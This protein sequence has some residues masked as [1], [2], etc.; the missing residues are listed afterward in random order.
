MITDPF[1]NSRSSAATLELPSGSILIRFAGAGSP[2]PI[3]SKPK[4]PAQAR[5]V[6]GDDHVVEV[7]RAELRDVGVDADLAVAA[8]AGSTRWSFIE[9]TSIEP[10]GIQPIPDGCPSTS[11]TVSSP[12]SAPTVTTWRR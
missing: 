3:K 11:I 10:S 5:A 8:G 4:L 6:G 7:A 2:K 1:G 9:T 12:P